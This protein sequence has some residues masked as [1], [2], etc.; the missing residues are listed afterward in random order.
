M[1]EGEN[2]IAI[3]DFGS[4][5]TLNIARNVRDLGIDRQVMGPGEV[6]DRVNE[7]SPAGIIL[8]GSKYSVYD[9]NAPTVNKGVLELGV[10]VLGICY[11]WQQIAHLLGGEVVKGGQTNRVV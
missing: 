5:T 10:P 3:V 2:Y 9:E 11:G 6:W 4:Q 7:H 1:Q 8:S